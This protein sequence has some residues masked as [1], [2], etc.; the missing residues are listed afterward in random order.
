MSTQG[1]NVAY[2]IDK[3]NTVLRL[4]H[5]KYTAR[6][7][8]LLRQQALIEQ[9]I[10]HIYDDLLK[11]NANLPKNTGKYI[12]P[13]S[14]I[15]YV[16][17]NERTTQKLK[18]LK[19]MAVT[20]PPPVNRITYA[21]ITPATDRTKRSLKL[22]SLKEYELNH[23]RKDSKNDIIT[24][25]THPDNDKSKNSI[26]TVG[27]IKTFFTRNALGDT[28]PII[29]TKKN[30]LDRVRDCLEIET[31]EECDIHVLKG[32]RGIKSKKHIDKHV[33]LGQ[34]VGTEYLASEFRE[35]YDNTNQEKERIKYKCSDTFWSHKTERDECIVIDGYDQVESLYP[36]VFIN[37]PR[38][39]FTGNSLYKINTQFISCLRNGYPI[40]LVI[41]SEKIEAG[42]SVWLDYGETYDAVMN[43][44]NEIEDRQQKM[45]KF[46]SSM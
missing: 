44:V 28:N 19:R 17:T 43:I 38:K 10:M 9:R 27:Q 22:F 15:Q 13:C 26:K 21:P 20:G 3:R 8:S 12:I 14:T 34:Y 1:W 23:F 18:L 25:R 30:Q 4:L 6:L 46:V 40:T 7:Q 2:I 24:V 39:N 35:L 31:I 32:Q 45:C 16:N 41:T 5:E 36:L 11:K 29:E 37:D 33:I 42:Q